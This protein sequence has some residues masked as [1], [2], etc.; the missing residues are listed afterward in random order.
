MSENNEHL[1][2]FH[3]P[4]GGGDVS[5]RQTRCENDFG[6]RSIAVCGAL[7]SWNI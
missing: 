6:N 2:P 3:E 1:L 7:D 4:E 5:L